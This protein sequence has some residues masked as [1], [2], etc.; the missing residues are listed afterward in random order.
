[1]LGY[2]GVMLL[3]GFLTSRDNAMR[4]L[5]LF[6]LAICSFTCAAEEDA[7]QK[8][9]NARYMGLVDQVIEGNLDSLELDK[10]LNDLLRM[11]KTLLRLDQ[12]KALLTAAVSQTLNHCRQR[13]QS[14]KKVSLQYVFQATG[15]L[16]KKIGEMYP[17]W[18]ALDVEVRRPFVVAITEFAL[19]PIERHDN[20]W[21][22][23][24]NQ[25]HEAG[26]HEA[27][28]KAF[29]KWSASPLFDDRI[30]GA[31]YKYNRENT[32]FSEIAYKYMR[33]EEQA[34]RALSRRDKWLLLGNSRV[35]ENLLGDMFNW[36]LDGLETS[37]ETKDREPLWLSTALSHAQII[38][39][40]K[41]DDLVK[42]VTE[43][44][45]DQEGSIEDKRNALWISV[46]L[47]D[48][49]FSEELLHSVF[50]ECLKSLLTEGV[51]TTAELCVAD[52]FPEMAVFAMN[53][54]FEIGEEQRADIGVYL[55]RFDEIHKNKR[56]DRYERYIGNWHAL[57]SLAMRHY[58]PEY[59]VDHLTIDAYLKTCSLMNKRNYAYFINSRGAVQWPEILSQ[60]LR[61]EEKF[62][63]DLAAFPGMQTN[64]KKR[65]DVFL[66]SSQGAIIVFLQAARVGHNINQTVLTNEVMYDLVKR[67]EKFQLVFWGLNLADYTELCDEIGDIR[68]AD[69]CLKHN[70]LKLKEKGQ[71]TLPASFGAT[72]LALIHKRLG[73][74]GWEDLLSSGLKNLPKGT[75]EWLLTAMGKEQAPPVPQALW[76]S[77]WTDVRH[78]S[79]VMTFLQSWK[80]LDPGSIKHI[81]DPN[82]LVSF[83]PGKRHSI[84]VLAALFGMLDATVLNQ[85]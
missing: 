3:K 85:K 71:D 2:T 27:M 14:E 6:V 78:K 4:L 61:A 21:I 50:K 5:L 12:A 80:H 13:A 49:R 36:A 23:C 15:A 33:A 40:I 83:I 81:V 45:G 82:C 75:D 63:S 57:L 77:I 25:L 41:N 59:V 17:E 43:V 20:E 30:K 51:N 22:Y 65:A 64:D 8:K 39:P 70:L 24:V 47:K 84:D 58:G 67:C 28:I 44:L 73:R 66:Q 38:G 16:I 26:A 69:D 74:P 60:Q 35:S 1:M 7:R 46:A 19:P 68:L 29:K 62:V 10:N 72:S 34:G 32:D 18:D 54:D 56:H 42:R 11:P 37:S 76:A 53:S 55:Q 79:D 9:I 52:G 48:C 31:F